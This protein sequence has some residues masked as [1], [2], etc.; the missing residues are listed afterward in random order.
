MKNCEVLKVNEEEINKIKNIFG[1]TKKDYKTL[2]SKI[3][4]EFGIRVVCITE[5][6]KGAFISSSDKVHYCPGYKIEGKDTVGSG[7]AFS[8]ALIMKLHE[9]YSATF[10]C[11]FACKIGALVASLNGAVPDYKLKDI[12]KIA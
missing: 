9:G 10:A 8:A 1:Y 11:D 5:G 12:E 3:K 7:D 2:I 6:E 4:K